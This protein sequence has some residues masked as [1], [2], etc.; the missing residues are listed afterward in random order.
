MEKRDI[1]ISIMI[2]VYNTSKYL[3]RCL[4]S[5]ISQSLKEIEI[6]CV[7]DGSTDNS[8]DILKKFQK[9]D[10]RIIIINKENGGLTS[11]RNAALKI[12]QGEYSLNID[13]DD[14]I[15]QDYL[16]KI[17]YKAKAEKIDMLITDINYCYETDNYKIE[18]DLLINDNEV[19][20]GR[21]YLKNFFKN[22]FLGYTWNKL[23]RTELYKKN[24]LKYNEKIFLF[25][26]VDLILRLS[27]YCEKVGKLNEAFYCYRQGEN[28]GVRKIKLKNLTDMIGCFDN[29]IEF[30]ETKEEWILKE[31]VQIKKLFYTSEILSNKYDNFN[32]YNDILLGYFNYIKTE[33]FIT[34]KFTSRNKRLFGKNERL[35]LCFSYNLI[36]I[37]PLKF[38]V[39][40][41]QKL[42]SILNHYK[43][44]KYK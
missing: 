12:A 36:K 30:Y 16:S 8:L 15:E 2:P 32:E 24:N 19:L 21:E 26:D 6:I 10:E 11:A 14:W 20:S 9:K 39:K 23:I 37:L 5:I 28:N 43:Q 31:L 44:E 17:Y 4:E 1:K 27:Y 42:K 41:L 34:E 33:K 40:I 29:L 13:S 18:K 3:A 22:N 7:N 38:I 25:E 35:F